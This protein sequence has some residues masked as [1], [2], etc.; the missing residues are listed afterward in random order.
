MKRIF[1]SSYRAFP[2]IINFKEPT[3]CTN[4]NAVQH[5]TEHFTSCANCYMFRHQGVYQ[6]QSFVGPTKKLLV[7]KRVTVGTWCEV[8]F[9]L[10]FTAFC[11]FVPKSKDSDGSSHPWRPHISPLRRDSNTWLPQNA[12]WLDIPQY[13]LYTI[14]LCTLYALTR[15]VQ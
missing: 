2:Y 8:C 10:Y 13:R 5:N 12:R 1:C 15:S 6:K 7:L 11:L 9:L 4:Q 3:K 14:T